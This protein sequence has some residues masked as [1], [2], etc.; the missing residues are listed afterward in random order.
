M[1]GSFKRPASGR[2]VRPLRAAGDS[3][4]GFFFSF[5]KTNDNVDVGRMIVASSSIRSLGLFGKPQHARAIWSSISVPG[6]ANA[7]WTWIQ[8]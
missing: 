6:G 1:G 5:S 3:C 8:I 7:V 4:F 2:S